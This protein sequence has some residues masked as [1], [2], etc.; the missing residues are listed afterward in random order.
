MFPFQGVPQVTSIV[1]D[2]T[3]VMLTCTSTGGPASRVTWLREGVAIT[4]TDQDY[5]MS[6][7]I[8]TFQDATY[9]SRLVGVAVG[10]LV[11]NFTCIV[12]NDRG[13][14]NAMLEVNCKG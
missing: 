3:E 4:D 7:R 10:S 12:E 1:H 6:Q 8:L 5:E 13:M 9:A 2:E 11:G 14:D